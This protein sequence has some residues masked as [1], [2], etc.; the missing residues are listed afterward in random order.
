MSAKTDFSTYVLPNQLSVTTVEPGDIFIRRAGDLGDQAQDLIIRPLANGVLG[1][2]S[3]GV[4][5][6]LSTLSLGSTLTVSGRT[7]LSGAVV[8]GVQRLSGAGAVNLTTP[9][10]ALTTTGSAQAL[11]LADGVDGQ[12]KEIIHDVD[13]GSAVLT[14]TTK[15]GFTT[16]TFTNVG[17]ACRLRFLTTR[18]WYIISLRNAVAA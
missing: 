5:G 14:P 15:T 1:F 6:V 2:D 13:G 7:T 4:L 8:G 11:T 10:T 18:G 17:D 3:N 16:I 9:V 12:E